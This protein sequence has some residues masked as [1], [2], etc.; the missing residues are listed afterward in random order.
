MKLLLTIAIF[1]ARKF[2]EIFICPAKAIG[3][4]AKK[5]GKEFIARKWYYNLLIALVIY[6]AFCLLGYGLESFVFTGSK[7][8]PLLLNIFFLWPIHGGLFI[9]V[10][11]FG[12]IL[13]YMLIALVF[14][15]AY[16]NLIPGLINFIISNWII[17]NINAK[18]N[19]YCVVNYHW[20]GY[21]TL[22]I[23][24]KKVYK[25]NSLLRHKLIS[26]RSFK[27]EYDNLE[28]AYFS[29]KTFRDRFNAEILNKPS[30]MYNVRYNIHLFFKR[31]A[32]SFN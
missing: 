28:Y 25:V 20:S 15:F 5:F 3:E 23:P 31:W 7:P 8:T 32:N 10:I 2:N 18:R 4:I 26:F 1:I 13:S 24:Y 22:I 16:F 19:K 14:L 21:H 11:V 29:I 6:A 17:S 30:R 9:F 27:P 12:G